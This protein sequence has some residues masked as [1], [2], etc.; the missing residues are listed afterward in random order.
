MLA[1]KV[2]PISMTVNNFL[3]NIISIYE[4]AESCMRGWLCV[5]G[6]FERFYHNASVA[7]RPSKSHSFI[8]M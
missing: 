8:W 4:Q 6:L 2:I 5:T 1:I 3:K 7:R